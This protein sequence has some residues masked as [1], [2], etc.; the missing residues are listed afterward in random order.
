MSDLIDRALKD[1]KETKIAIIDEGA[2]ERTAKAFTQLFG[3]AT[4]TA[5]V[6]ADERTMAVAGNRVVEVLKEAGVPQLDPFVFP[7]DPELYASYE[8]VEVVRDMLAGVDAY[9]I[10]VGS[11]TVNDLVKRACGELERPYMQVGTAASV[12]G[13][14]SFGASITNQGFKITH[15]C[16]APVGSVSDTAVMAAAPQVMTATGYGDLIGKVPAGADWMIAD[17]L[18]IEA[19]NPQVWDLVQGPLRGA[20]AHPE[21]L[22]KGDVGAITDLT[23]GLIMSGLAMQMMQSSR[24]ASG[25]EHQFSH[26][27]EMEGLGIDI[28]PRRLSHGFK[29]G[30]GT[31]SIS[32][33]YECLLARD[34]A[35]LDTDEAIAKW[36]TKDHMESKVREYF[37]IP[38]IVD[39][40]VKQQLSKW[41]T[42]EQLA[43]RIELLKKLW[44]ELSQK[45]R[46]QLLPTDDVENRLETVGAPI[47][48]SQIGVDW[49]RF[50]MTYL[51]CGMIR[52]RYTVLDTVNELGLLEEIVDELFS[53]DGFWGKRRP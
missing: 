36:P 27:W 39:T 52:A 19:I 33:L 37:P 17:A 8:N 31:I 18:G 46:A 28:K 9:A 3:S 50:R 51:R 38:R 24:S 42:P 26:L 1:A 15:E 48:P 7:G 4:A 2:V 20:L 43:E 11:G 23:E 10:A 5:I 34:I 22:A 41:V 49:D 21:L 47:H 45:I 30:L 44:P 53:D 12:D 25:A 6:I 35:S 32:A 13:Y 40:I 29:V 14:T 16:P